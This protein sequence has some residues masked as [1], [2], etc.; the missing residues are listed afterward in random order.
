MKREEYIQAVLVKLEEVSPYNDIADGLIAVAGDSTARKVK[1]I[2]TYIDECLDEACCDVMQIIPLSRL[3][4]DTIDIEDEV[5]SDGKGVLHISIPCNFLRFVRLHQNFLNRDVY[6]LIHQDSPAYMLQQNP[7]ARGGRVKPV[8]AMVANDYERKIE[9]YSV[10]N[11]T[12]CSYR[13]TYIPRLKAEGVCSKIEEE[14]II[15]T[16]IKVLNIFGNDTKVMQ[17]ELTNKIQII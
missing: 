5:K 6:H 4:A 11:K 8:A 10:P 16:A 2:A 17:D 15:M 14:I 13:L 7:F 12:S 3:G 9:L 1:P